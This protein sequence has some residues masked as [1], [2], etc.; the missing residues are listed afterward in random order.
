MVRYG[1]RMALQ[2]KP[3]RSLQMLVKKSTVCSVLLCFSLSVS[4]RLLQEGQK[5]P[6]VSSLSG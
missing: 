1:T 5:E 3:H 6:P 4:E 2:H